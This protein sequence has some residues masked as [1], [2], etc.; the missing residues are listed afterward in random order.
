ME[1]LSPR[2]EHSV[3]FGLVKAKEPVTLS[4]RNEIIY[5]QSLQKY[6]TELCDP[7]SATAFNH[8]YIYLP[9]RSAKFTATVVMKGHTDMFLHSSLLLRVGSSTQV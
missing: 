3:P 5:F 8:K 1:L 7:V 9:L 4:L 2:F 6:E